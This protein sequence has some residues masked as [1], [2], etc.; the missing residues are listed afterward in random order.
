MKVLIYEPNKV[1]ENFL[2]NYMFS[3]SIVPM[4]I[5]D[6]SRILPQLS[7]REFDIFISDYSDNQEII[8][9]IIFNLKLNSDLLFIRIFITTPTPEKEVLHNLIKLGIN[10]FIKKPFLEQQF[11][12]TFETW[13]GK[14]TFKNNR[15]VHIRVQ[16]QPADNAFALIHT[17]YRN[18]DVKFEIVDISVGGLALKPPA[19]FERLVLK[20]FTPGDA[21]LEVRIKI[22][23]FG[24]FVDLKIVNVQRDRICFSFLNANDKT[25]KYIYRYIADNIS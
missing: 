24:I 12:T 2:A 14:N 4:V 19:S 15:R 10:G 7:L 13:L 3:K 23:H 22:R 8:N 17:K 6:P 21:L 11:R 5:S 16:P 20:M 1:L 18:A 9:D 25:H